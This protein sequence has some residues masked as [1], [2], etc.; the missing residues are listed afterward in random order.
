[1][2]FLKNL[3][4]MFKTVLSTIAINHLNSK[5]RKFE[6]TIYMVI[7]ILLVV[8]IQIPKLSYDIKGLVSQFQSFVAIFIAFRFGYFGFILE[9]LLVLPVTYNLIFLFIKY[10]TTNFILAITVQA[11]TIVISYIAAVYSNRQETQRNRLKSL[12]ITDELTGVYNVRYFHSTLA[13]EI[14]LAQKSANTVGLVMVDIDNFKM[15]NDIYGHD[16]GD[17]ILKLTAGTLKNILRENEILCR[18]GGDEFAIILKNTDKIDMEQAANRIKKEFQERKSIKTKCNIFS[19]VTLSMG[20]SEYPDLSKNKDELIYQADMALY[21]AKNLTKD[22]VHFYQDVILQIRKNIS[23]DN[24]QLIGIFKGLLSTISAKDKYTHGHCERV[25]QYAVLIGEAMNLNLKEITVLQYSGLLHDIGKIEMPKTILNKI[26]GLTPDEYDSI[27][28]HPVFS[29][30]I[31]EPL[32][33]MSQLIEHVRHHHE[34]F[35]GKGYPDGLAGEDISLGAR[36]LCVADSFDAMLSERP[37]SKSMAPE[38]AIS[39]LEKCSG[40]HF[41]PK[42]VNIFTGIIRSRLLPG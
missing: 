22:S 38:E 17:S 12:A 29:A 35:D 13:E 36:I 8:I 18:F 20:L 42:I 21:H 26:G 16:C 33:E 39:E 37:Y 7:N 6:L 34:R 30:N 4:S 9:V 15:F 19:E 28:M 2:V 27:Q 32:A 10:G 5:Y 14:D 11:S 24:Q 41:D 3:F 31:L 1:M 40:T 25:S 23:S